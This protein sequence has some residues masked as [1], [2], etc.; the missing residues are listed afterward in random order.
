MTEVAEEM[1]KA[2]IPEATFLDE[3]LESQSSNF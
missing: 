1:A 2:R 3:T